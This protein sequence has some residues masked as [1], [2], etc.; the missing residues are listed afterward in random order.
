[1]PTKVVLITGAS[2]GIGKACAE[3]LSQIGYKVYGTTRFINNLGQGNGKY[4]MIQMDI[5]SDHSVKNGIN[6]V[7]EKEGRL[8]VVLNNAGFILAGSIED[9]TIEEA[10]TQLEANLFGAFRVCREALPKM[11]EQMSGYI[12]NISSIGGLMGLPF[13]GLYSASKFALEGLTEALRMEIKQHGIRVVLI[14]PGDFKTQLTTNRIRVKGSLENP[15]YK[16]NF[17]KAVTRM[18]IDETHGA[19]PIKVA[20]L[21]ARI[22]RT[23][24]PR[25]RYSIGPVT[26]RVA[27]V[28]KKILPFSLF[29]KALMKY[30]GLG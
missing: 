15:A 30:Y 12:I 26:E 28:L 10:K 20:H 8:D 4:R 1:M 22:L 25:L 29:E 6:Q 16:V 9:T 21:A 17:E 24:A 3:H 27:I 18:E 2:S 5:N 11:R 23:P 14:E 7:F 13:H 19:D